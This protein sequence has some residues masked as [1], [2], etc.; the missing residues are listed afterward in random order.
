[1]HT[2]EGKVLQAMG[3]ADAKALMQ[4]HAW[5]V[6]G[7]VRWAVCLEQKKLVRSLG[8]KMEGLAHFTWVLQAIRLCLFQGVRW[9][10]MERLRERTDVFKPGALVSLFYNSVLHN[11]LPCHL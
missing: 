6:R 4:M 11:L 9:E 2:C 5:H 10:S 1:M 3:T 8:G 7:T